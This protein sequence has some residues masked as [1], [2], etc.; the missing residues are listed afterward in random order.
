VARPTKFDRD[1]VLQAA[2]E[3]FRDSGY[4]ATR[5]PELVHATQLQP[6]SLYAAFD[7]KQGLLEASLQHYAGQSL[8][9]IKATIEG[10]ISPLQGVKQVL[11]NVVEESIED[12][13]GC[14]L[15]N[16]LLELS[17]SDTGLRNKIL[18]YLADIETCLVHALQQAQSQGELGDD[19]EPVAMAKF[20]MVNMWG[21]KVL[22]KT[23]AG[24]ASINDALKTL[25]AFL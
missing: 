2:I 23:D 6:G 22:A 1:T 11:V 21:F 19:K 3:A 10:A 8:A 24:N 5:M 4:C 9:A 14:L 18:A 13:R 17:S 16:T 15:V 20:L 12:K 25:L 7:S